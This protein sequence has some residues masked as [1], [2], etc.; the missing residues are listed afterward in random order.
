MIAL[1]VLSLFWGYNWVVMKEILRYVGP[2]QFGAIR[3]FFGSL[4]LFAILLALGKPLHL[5]HAWRVASIGLLQTGCFTALIVYA[6]MSGGAGKVAVLT[7]S[8]PFWVMILAWPL[9]GEKLRGL[10]WLAALASVLGLLLIVE[11]WHMQG[12]LLSSVL[13]VIAGVCWALAVILAKQLHQQTLRMDLLAFTA[14]QMLIGSLPLV[15]LGVLMPAPPIQWTGYFIGAA[16]YNVIACNALAWLLW[17][18]ALQ[19]LPAGVASMVSLLTPVVGV[20]AA[21][22]Q[23]HE[24]PTAAELIGM[25][26]IAF[27]IMVL[28]WRGMRRHEEVEPA[29]A[30]E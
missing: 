13:A 21:W 10:Q 28:A 17:L 24:A 2:F 4:L 15:L 12:S 8:M 7:Y 3:T 14:W 22:M 6:L 16:L 26:S 20:L 1:L 27:A 30:Q 29:L 19:H 18:Y 23:L 11:P 5:Q 25:L 9:L